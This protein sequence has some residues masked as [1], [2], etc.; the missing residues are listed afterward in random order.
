MRIEYK[1]D[2]ERRVVKKLKKKGEMTLLSIRRR[3]LFYSQG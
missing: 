1:N 2:E 3:K